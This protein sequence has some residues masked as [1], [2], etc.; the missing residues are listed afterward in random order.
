[1]AQQVTALA[2]TLENL[3]SIPEVHAGE[4]E[5]W[6]PKLSSNLHLCAWSVNHPAR[7]LL[8]RKAGSPEGMLWSWEKLSP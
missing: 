6:L 7:K 2:V 3:N 8:L 5:N 4:G 1:M